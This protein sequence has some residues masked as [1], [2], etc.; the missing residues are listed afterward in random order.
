MSVE[1]P[2]STV[3]FLAK[4]ETCFFGGQGGLSK[5]DFDNDS[6]YHLSDEAVNFIFE[7]NREILWIGIGGGSGAGGG[8][9]KYNRATGERERFSNIVGD[10]SSLPS[11]FI[12]SIA[13]DHKG[14]IW[15]GLRTR[16]CAA[17][18]QPQGHL[19]LF[20]KKMDRAKV[21]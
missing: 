3:L 14:V 9:L 10:T 15:I 17:L 11:N 13:E 8:L 16:D 19:P 6:V 21:K 1:L 2:L 18:M 12:A 20:L 7:D 4:T 5:F